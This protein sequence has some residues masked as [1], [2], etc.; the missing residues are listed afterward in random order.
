MHTILEFIAQGQVLCQRKVLAQPITSSS[1]SLDPFSPTDNHLLLLGH[2]KLNTI[3]HLSGSYHW[4]ILYFD[5][6]DRFAGAA[7]AADHGEG[8][9]GLIIQAK[10][11]VL[12]RP[13]QQ[14]GT[15]RLTALQ[16]LRYI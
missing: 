11:V 7:I 12:L 13:G 14:L 6:D 9:F 16:Q 5:A 3:L 2:E 10:K 4:Q 1:H 8:D 15:Q